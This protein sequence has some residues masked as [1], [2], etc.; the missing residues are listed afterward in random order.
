[1]SRCAKTLTLR[2]YVANSEN[3][4]GDVH[5]YTV[6][7]STCALAACTSTIRSDISQLPQL[8]SRPDYRSTL[9]WDDLRVFLEVARRGGLSQAARQ[10]GLDH[11]T[12]SR[13][14][15]QLELTMGTKLFERT[16]S[17]L[18]LRPAGQLLLQNAEAIESRALAVTASISSEA[19]E[20]RGT[21]RIAM[22]EGI[23][24]LYLS[25]RLL[26]LQTNYP[27]VTLE[28]VTSA[29]PFNLSRR[30]ADIFLSFFR[31]TG[32]GLGIRKIGAFELSLYGSPA[33]LKRHGTPATVEDLQ[34]HWFVDYVHDLVAIDA[35]RWLSD[36]IANPKVIFHS[37]SMI[38][39]QHAAIGGLGLVMLPSFAATGDRRLQKI[40]IKNVFVHRDLW[41]SVHRDLQ[42]VRRIRAVT[43]FITDLVK[44]DQDYLM[45]R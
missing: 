11:S 10:L 45:A 4:Q 34:Q 29:H 28:L 14:V 33:Y 15:A 1:M 39:Q 44:R 21:V 42:N 30:E 7:R 6:T 19:H 8:Q 41:L 23:G 13:R 20:P 27:Q 24:S 2:Y 40:T 3:S 37:N 5:K 12:V 43:D 17:G 36:V 18:V 26:S 31:P 9:N 16:R 38:A 22:M 25:A 35:V 32:R